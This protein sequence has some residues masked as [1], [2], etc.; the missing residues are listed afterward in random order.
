MADMWRDGI[1]EN[2]W[3]QDHFRDLNLESSLIPPPAVMLI[4][5]G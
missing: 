4:A 1:R 3:A 2:G 5:R